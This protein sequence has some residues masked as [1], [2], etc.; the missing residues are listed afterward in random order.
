MAVAMDKQQRL[1]KANQLIKS[2]AQCGRQF[3]YNKE[4]DRTA[5]IELDPRGRIW[6][7]DDYTGTRI[8]THYSHRWRGFSHGATMR[9]LVE[10]LRNYVFKGTLLPEGIFGPWPQWYSQGD[11]WG[12]GDDMQKVRKAAAD[13]GLLSVKRDVKEIA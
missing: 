6:W 8:Y 10:H 2:I 11:P 13:L 1:E 5:S 7:I 12:Y 9:T 4:H 3:F